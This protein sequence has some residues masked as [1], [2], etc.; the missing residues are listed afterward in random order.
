MGAGVECDT[1]SSWQPK[2][3]IPRVG[4]P[5][6]GAYLQLFDIEQR[7]FFFP[8]RIVLALIGYGIRGTQ[9][10]IADARSLDEQTK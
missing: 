1:G 7:R 8:E 9:M 6:A 3:K 2:P 5:N 10:K 4:R